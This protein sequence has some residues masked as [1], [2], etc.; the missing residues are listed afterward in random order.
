MSLFQEYEK[1]KEANQLLTPGSI[2]EDTVGEVEIVSTTSSHVNYI[3]THTGGYDYYL[4]RAFLQEF[5][6]VG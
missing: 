2:W 3:N 1:L 5:H 6:R 4:K